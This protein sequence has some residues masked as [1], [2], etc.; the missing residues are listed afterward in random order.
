LIRSL[1]DA[2][3]EALLLKGAAMILRYYEDAGLRPMADLDVMVRQDQTLLAFV[4]L[5]KLGWVSQQQPDPTTLAAAHSAPFTRPGASPLDLH[6]RLLEDEAP[7]P[8]DQALW[9]RAAPVDL[10]GVPT[11]ALGATDQLLHLLAHGSRWSADRS[12]RWLADASVLLSRAQPEIDWEQ[13][14]MEARQRRVHLAAQQALDFLRA[15]LDAPVPEEAL[16]HLSAAPVGRLE[17]WE[18]RARTRCPERR[19]PLLMGAL[20]YQSY[21]RLVQGGALAPGALGFLRAVGREWGGVP[22]WRV[23]FLAVGKGLRRMAQ[24]AAGW[25]RKRR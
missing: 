13:L 11:R 22:T 16:D 14:A 4:H 6:W 21:R 5:A 7:A 25:S 15:F 3:I 17:R 19:G 8:G 23:P 24:L 10:F 20:H 18:H 2:G 1:E 12:H 9:F